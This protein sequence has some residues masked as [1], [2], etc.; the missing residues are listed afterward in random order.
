MDNY[1]ILNQTDGFEWWI[2]ALPQGGIIDFRRSYF[3]RRKANNMEKALS[4]KLSAFSGGRGWIRTTEVVDNRFTVCPLWPLGNSSILN[5]GA[6]GRTRTPDLLI[7]NQLLYQL[8]YTSDFVHRVNA[9]RN[10]PYFCG[11]VKS[12]FIFL[13]KKSSARKNVRKDGQKALF[14]VH[15][16]RQSIPFFCDN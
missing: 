11:Q 4:V 7:T 2:A 10:I 15:T 13:K 9:R 12:F 3:I 5:C 6:G 16:G 1:Y 8:S 14:S